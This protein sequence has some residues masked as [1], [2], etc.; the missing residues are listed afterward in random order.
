MSKVCIN[1]LYTQY[2]R[3]WTV[4]QTQHP[5]SLHI[6]V[7]PNMTALLSRM[8]LETE[9]GLVRSYSTQDQPS[10]Q[11]LFTAVAVVGKKANANA[12]YWPVPTTLGAASIPSSL[13]YFSIRKTVG[14]RINDSDLGADLVTLSQGDAA[15]QHIGRM[16]RKP[17]CSSP[18]FTNC[19]K[20]LH[21][22]TVT[23]TIRHGEVYEQTWLRVYSQASGSVRLYSGLN[24]QLANTFMFSKHNVDHVVTFILR[25]TLMSVP[26]FMAIHPIDVDT[27]R[28]KSQCGAKRKVR[29]SPKCLS[30]ILWE[31][32]KSAL[33][34][35]S[36]HL[37]DVEI[38][39]R[40]S[41][42]FQLL[43]ALQER[44]G[45]HQSQ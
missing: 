40:I 5:G 6:D 45:D 8:C 11:E 16:C 24:A 21:A 20:I 41:K 10:G 30:F 29:E 25:G 36:V 28:P 2:T 22:C 42:N 38:C 37:I 32:W 19:M 7:W 33:N 26:N 43:V 12:H 15:F 9:P 44:S 23:G 1:R 39:Q 31:Q 4:P 17:P 27:F 35:V 3:G 34:G 18:W 13:A 14:V